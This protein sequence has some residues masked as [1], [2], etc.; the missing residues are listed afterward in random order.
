MS[1]DPRPL[2]APLVPGTGNRL[3]TNPMMDILDPPSIKNQ[4][5][6]VLRNVQINGNYGNISNG[7]INFEITPRQSASELYQQLNYHPAATPPAQAPAPQPQH[8]QHT[9]TQEVH[10]SVDPVSWHMDKPYA[11]RGQGDHSDQSHPERI[12]QA[13]N[14]QTKP[15]DVQVPNPQ[16]QPQIRDSPRHEN[17]SHSGGESHKAPSDRTSKGHA[18]T[19]SAS[20]DSLKSSMP[21][22]FQV[23]YKG[24]L[25]KIMI[26]CEKVPSK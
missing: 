15:A 9:Q 20:M 22:T 3:A 7:N 4:V 11:G 13:P 12:P 17:R 23:W 24:D 18:H 21:I 8:T 5:F 14:Y 10:K 1:N 16:D 19:H 25:G 26:N 6:D 2:V